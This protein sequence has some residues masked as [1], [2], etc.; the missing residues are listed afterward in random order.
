[1]FFDTVVLVKAKANLLS[2]IE[3]KK[4]LEKLSNKEKELQEFAKESKEYKKYIKPRF[5]RSQTIR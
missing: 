4:E 1:M 3:L 5:A 2:N